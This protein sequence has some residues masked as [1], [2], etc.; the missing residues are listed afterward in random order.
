MYHIYISDLN[1]PLS[2]TNHRSL[3]CLLLGFR[4]FTWPENYAAVSLA[5]GVAA[6]PPVSPGFNVGERDMGGQKKCRQSPLVGKLSVDLACGL[7]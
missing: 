1:C 3:R 4:M 2:S 6:S 7:K 5:T